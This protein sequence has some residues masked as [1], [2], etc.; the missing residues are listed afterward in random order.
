MLQLFSILAHSIDA[1]TVTSSLVSSKLEIDIRARAD[2]IEHGRPSKIELLVSRG[3]KFVSKPLFG[4][5]AVGPAVGV[6]HGHGH[7]FED[8]A[9]NPELRRASWLELCDCSL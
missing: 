6:A 5:P 2:R 4:S 1:D 9:C 8:H 3:I 7:V